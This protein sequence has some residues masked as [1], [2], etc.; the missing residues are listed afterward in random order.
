M[1]EQMNYDAQDLRA[2]E[3]S[4]RLDANEGVFFARQLEFI[5]SQ[6][7]DV[8]RPQ[9]NA[10]RLLPVS[11]ATPEGAT[12]ITYRQYDTVGL[13]KIIANYANDL[14][15][16]DV[17]GREFTSPIR[18]I[19]VSYGYNMQ[20]IRSAQFAGVPLA[21]RKMT[22]AMRAHEE[23]INRLA[24]S[25]DTENGLP[26]FLTNANIP[27]YTVPA[28]GTASSKLWTAKTADLIIRDVNGIINLVKTQSRGIHS[29]NRVMMPLEQLAYIA[30][31]P[32]SSTSDTTILEF[33]QRVNPGV[34][35]EGVLELDQAGAGST[36]LLIAG[37]FTIDN[38]QLEIPMLFRQYSPQQKG[39]EFEIPCESRFGGVLIPYPLAFAAGT[40]I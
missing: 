21:S 8:K 36:D 35:F 11:T 16:A 20:E 28:D 12:T 34:A 13:A 33:L 7:Y 26:G 9:L 3:A 29:A 17:S 38:M 24:W 32:R 37:E 30:S 22:A 31:V 39:L 27:A 40:G 6:S 2:I 15:R 10:L 5:K 25:G 18:G 4:G 19:G 23:L 14:P 1:N